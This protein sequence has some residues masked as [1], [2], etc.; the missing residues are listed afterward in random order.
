MHLRNNGMRTTLMPVS[1]ADTAETWREAAARRGI[2]SLLFL[3]GTGER[4]QFT[5]TRSGESHFLALSDYLG[6]GDA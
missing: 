5:D 1:P 3:A 2:R 4:I 6:E